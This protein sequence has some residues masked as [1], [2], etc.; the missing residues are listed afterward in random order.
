MKYLH[1][2]LK[3]EASMFVYIKLYPIK[4]N[5]LTMISNTQIESPES[6][7]LL[8]FIYNLDAR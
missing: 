5:M 1:I 3:K 6:Q 8:L 2:K 4:T 7:S